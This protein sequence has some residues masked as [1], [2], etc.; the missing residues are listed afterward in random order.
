MQF[1][2]LEEVEVGAV[3][4][5]KTELVKNQGCLYFAPSKNKTK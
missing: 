2:S 1:V 3:K 4:P 5:V